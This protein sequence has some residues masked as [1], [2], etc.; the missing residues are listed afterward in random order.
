MIIAALFLIP[1]IW[2]IAMTVDLMEFFCYK[3]SDLENK[4]Q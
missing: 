3:I 1:L 4:D 2:V